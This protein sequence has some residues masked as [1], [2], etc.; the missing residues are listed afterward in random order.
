MTR[1][2]R[3]NDPRY[4]EV[5]DR[6][7]RKYVRDQVVLSDEVMSLLGTY[8]ELTRSRLCVMVG[9]SG[10]LVERVLTDLM[11][12]GRVTRIK[13]AGPQGQTCYFWSAVDASGAGAR[14]NAA[15]ILGVFQRKAA[16]CAQ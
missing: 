12:S 14:F 7:V 11:S 9:A 8:G 1:T 15:T 3:S 13:R 6:G 5:V 2:S 10:P 16:D 4:V